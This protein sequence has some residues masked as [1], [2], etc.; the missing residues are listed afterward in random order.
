MKLVQA[1]E[2]GFIISTGFESAPLSSIHPLSERQRI[3]CKQASLPFRSLQGSSR[4]ARG[5]P[6]CGA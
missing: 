1:S 5:P 3:A 6:D 2:Q 4:T